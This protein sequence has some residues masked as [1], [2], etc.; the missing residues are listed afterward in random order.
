MSTRELHP[1]LYG[2]VWGVQH[3]VH[4]GGETAGKGQTKHRLE[5][6]GSN[7]NLLLTLETG[8]ETLGTEP[9]RGVEHTEQIL[10]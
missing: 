8:S 1:S 3:H 5:A 2:H 6:L 10:S 9:W 7:A 4:H